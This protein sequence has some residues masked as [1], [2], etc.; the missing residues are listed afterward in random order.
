MHMKRRL[1]DSCRPQGAPGVTGPRVST[2]TTKHGIGAASWS[3]R[4][5]RQ[6][7]GPVR[8]EPPPPLEFRWRR[9]PSS[10]HGHEDPWISDSERWA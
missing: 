4:L 9:V 10:V 6:I 8:Q 7:R 5:T 2:T 3:Q 1:G